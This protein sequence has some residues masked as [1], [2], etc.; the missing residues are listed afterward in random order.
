[1]VGRPAR[2]VKKEHRTP[3][4][5]APPAME[6]RVE[7]RRIKEEVEADRVL[8]FGA[9]GEES[10]D[11]D[12]VGPEPEAASPP[13]ADG[14][15]DEVR[16]RV[17]SQQLAKVLLGLEEQEEGVDRRAEHKEEEEEPADSLAA[18][19]PRAQGGR[20]DDGEKVGRPLLDAS[21]SIQHCISLSPA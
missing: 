10:Q 8:D 18:A 14:V 2:G 17:G 1:M 21:G 19:L 12:R 4:G 9:E 5:A 13:A 7:D 11:R 16:E 15:E 20:E 6:G 3:V